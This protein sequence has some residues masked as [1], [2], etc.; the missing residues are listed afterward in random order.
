M[1]ATTFS[2]EKKNLKERLEQIMHYK[3]SRVRTLAAVLALI[4][5]FGC[6]L[7][8]GPAS[9]GSAE[10]STDGQ[11]VVRVS[12]VD[13]FLAA[14]APDTVIELA[15]G[16][17]DLSSAANYAGESQSPY[18]GWTGV[19]SENGDPSAELELRSLENLTI[20]GS[21]M[22]ETTIAAVPR[23]ANVLKLSSCRGVTLEQLTAGHT[24]EPGFC[25]GGVLSFD[26]CSDISVNE[27]G[28]YGCGTIGVQARDCNDL[29][30]TACNVYECS[31][32]A[33][34][35]RSGTRAG[36]GGAMNLFDLAYS[37]GAVIRRNRIHDNNVQYL[38]HSSYTQNAFFLSNEVENNAIVTCGF[39]LEEYGVTIDGCS[40][41]N[42]ELRSGWLY[43]NGVYAN[44]TA[45]N[46]LDS[47]ALASMTWQ[48]LE[49]V[50]AVTP[51]QPDPA[52]FLA[53]GASVE[54]TSI[55]KRPRTGSDDCAEWGAL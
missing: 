35:A 26:L 5:L 34:E 38:L 17:Y 41:R 49:P 14:L 3:K 4:V 43:G 46:L 19:Y 6:G 33:L 40:F 44:D 21:G 20:R 29:T 12:T 23:Y 10:I 39:A 24:T 13:E 30:V 48:D 53:A 16:T 42:N 22:T 54:V 52:M 45:G 28:L 32:G 11:N 1:V 50:S 51:L 25:A 15:P 9:A 36:Q 18:Y 2:T 7:A 47:E 27:C 8:A 31:Y 37:D 55:L